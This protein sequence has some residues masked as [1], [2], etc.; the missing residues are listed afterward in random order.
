MFAV[1]LP[2][3]GP[4]GSVPRVDAAAHPRLTVTMKE[5]TQA[6]L[7]LGGPNLMR[8]KVLQNTGLG[9]RKHR[10]QDR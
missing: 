8:H 6:V 1:S 5:M 7:P 9:L 4:A 3:F 10:F 2:V